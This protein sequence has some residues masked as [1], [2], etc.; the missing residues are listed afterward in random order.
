MTVYWSTLTSIITKRVFRKLQAL[1]QHDDGDGG[2]NWSKWKCVG[3]NKVLN[4]DMTYLIHKLALLKWENFRSNRIYWEASWYNI[5]LLIFKDV[6]PFSLEVR[7]WIGIG[8]NRSTSG[9]NKQMFHIFWK[10]I[11]FRN[12]LAPQLLIILGMTRR[13]LW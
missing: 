4:K 10:K 2:G 8:I 9:G 3:S 13:H 7:G 12:T 5:P 1:V 11:I 6:S